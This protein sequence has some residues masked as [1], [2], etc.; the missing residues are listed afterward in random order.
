MHGARGSFWRLSLK[1]CKGAEGALTAGLA[2]AQGPAHTP[3]ASGQAWPNYTASGGEGADLWIRTSEWDRDGRDSTGLQGGE[4]V[5]LGT[6]RKAGG[7]GRASW[8]TGLG[9]GL[10]DVQATSLS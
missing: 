2:R 8:E 10:E 1:S 6:Q 3:E 5:G 9:S 7:S 4:V